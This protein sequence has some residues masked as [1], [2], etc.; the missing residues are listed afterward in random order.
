MSLSITCPYT[1]CVWL[2]IDECDVRKSNWA[3]I[4]WGSVGQRGDDA[5]D[6]DIINVRR[7]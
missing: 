6:N 2:H 4:F 5:V 7:C 3:D 1:R